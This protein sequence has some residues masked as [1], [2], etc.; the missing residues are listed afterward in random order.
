MFPVLFRLDRPTDHS[1][2]ACVALDTILD[3]GT[4]EQAD[5]DGT[6]GMSA[7]TLPPS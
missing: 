4:R 7:A 6:H 2:P 1:H 5:I 3:G